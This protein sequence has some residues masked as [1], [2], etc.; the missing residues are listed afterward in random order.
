LSAEDE[1]FDVRSLALGFR[2][3]AVLADHRHPWGQL[4]FAEQGVMQVFTEHQAWTVPPTK[5]IWIPVALGHHIRMQSDVAMRT[6]Y[7]APHRAQSLG[8]APLAVEVEPLLRHLI[9]HILEL[10][11]LS[12][13]V[14]AQD[15]LGGVLIDRLIDAPRQDLA[16]PLPRD[17]RAR[18]LA[19]HLQASHADT[20]ALDALARRH[21]ASLRTMQRLFSKETHL[22]LEAWRQKARLIHAVSRLAAGSGVTQAAFDRGYRSV[23][24]FTSAFK[25]QF[26]VT[27]GRYL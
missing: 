7:V 12:P 8:P 26:N 13:S 11:M 3:G 9:L 14:A 15:R 10:G 16:L 6:L 19:D 2:S 1:V 24:A 20:T 25:R 21:G 18:N 17:P 5:A 27:P 22:T 23:G 4:I